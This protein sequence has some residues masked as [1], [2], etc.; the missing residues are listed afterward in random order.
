M[1]TSH[2]QNQAAKDGNE[3]VVSPSSVSPLPCIGNEGSE[4]HP[5][6]RKVRGL[7]PP[8]QELEEISF[9]LM[10]A[11]EERLFDLQ[12]AQNRK[13]RQQLRGEAQGLENTVKALKQ[14][15]QNQIKHMNMDKE[16][17]YRFGAQ[18]RHFAAVIRMVPDG[19]VNETLL[20][21][22]PFTMCGYKKAMY[23]HASEEVRM[24]REA[25]AR[26]EELDGCRIR[27]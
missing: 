21:A 24:A 4:A 26:K 16:E 6:I 3:S 9:P 7:T 20:E 23:E 17:K 25:L 1:G 13:P 5:P 11:E 19:M 10:E 22:T 15:I 14:H 12:L 8:E 27:A 18:C 2:A